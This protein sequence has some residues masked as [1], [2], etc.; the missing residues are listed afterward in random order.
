MRIYHT[1]AD[2]RGRQVYQSLSVE[3]DRM[4]ELNSRPSWDETW[5]TFA[6][7]L[8]KRSHDEKY[9]VGAVIVTRE[10]TQMLSHG[11]NG[12]A[13]GLPHEKESEVPGESGFIHAE[14]N[15]LIKL[16]FNNPSKKVMYVTLS[17]CRMCAKLIMNA[18]IDEVVY[19][20]KYRDLSGIKMLQENGVKVRQF[21]ITEELD[22]AAKRGRVP[23]RR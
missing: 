22:R 8:A 18:K 19:H 15:A 14:V 17:P 4:G 11:Y 3:E 9:R 1:G 10:N 23:K 6:K 7:V 13:T 2:S 12:N 5:M 21:R 16:D 20:D